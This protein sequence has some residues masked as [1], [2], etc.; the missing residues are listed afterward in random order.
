MMSMQPYMQQCETFNDVY[1]TNGINV[2]QGCNQR[3]ELGP[4]PEAGVSGYLSSA[5]RWTNA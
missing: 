3:H 2:A 4:E 1:V 5:F